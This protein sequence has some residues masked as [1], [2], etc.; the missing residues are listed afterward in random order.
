[1]IAPLLLAALSPL[2][3]QD[4]LSPA[5]KREGFVSLFNGRDLDGWDGDKSLWKVENGVLVGLSDGRPFKVNTFLSYTR[6]TDYSDFVLRADVKLRNHNSGIHFRSK[7]LPEPGWIVMGYQADCSHAGEKSAWGNFYEERGRGRNVMKNPNE[8]WNAAQNVLR[9][10]DWNS[11]E[12]FADGPRIKLHFNGIQT[13]DTTDTVASSG[14][15]ALQLHAGEEMR[16][17]FRNIRIK[18]LKR[19]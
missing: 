14:I 8:G 10:K 7:Q 13:I 4:S 12:I 1:M 15:V 2:F 19:R 11:Y 6:K 9:A 3:A 16:V 17:E 18:E 5:E